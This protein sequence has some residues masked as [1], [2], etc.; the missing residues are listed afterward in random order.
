MQPNDIDALLGSIS[1]QSFKDQVKEVAPSLELS[2]NNA[3]AMQSLVTLVEEY[4][5][6]L[7]NSGT[8]KWFVEGSAFS[9][10][11]CPKHNAFFMASKSYTETLFIAGNRCGKTLA[12]AFAMAC[13]LTGEYP[14]WWNGK[15]F[16]RPIKA[17]AAGSDAKSTRDTVQKELLG[18]IGNW[19]TG[20]IPKEKMGRFWALSGVPQGVD[21]IEIKHSSGGISTLSFK[22]YQ[23][24]LSAFYGTAMDVIWLDEICPA[25]IYNECLIRTMTTGGIIFVTFTPLEGLTPLVVNF[26]S[27]ADLLAGSKPLLG[28]SN[29]QPEDDGT[30][31]RLANRTVAKA[32]V[33]AGW[34]DAP[35]LTEEAKARML[36]DTPPHLRAARS[37][38][39]PSMGSGNIYPIPLS[40]I[41]IKPFEIPPYYER[42]CG[43]DVGWNNTAAVWLAKNPD[44]G[45]VYMYDEY[46]RG[47]EEPPV[48]ASA[49]KARGTWI[50][51][52]IDPASRGR[53]QVDGRKLMDMYR[54]EDLLLYPA[55]NE[56]ESG[57]L[58][59]WSHLSTGKL[60]I[61]ETLPRIQREYTLYRRDLN[62]KVI[63]EN[64]HL[65]DALRYALNMIIRAI[66]KQQA[67]SVGKGLKGFTTSMKYDI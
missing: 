19:G 42:I 41:L 8:G 64:D 65:L 61:F 22:N 2:D 13:H 50:P 51:V 34:D 59:V 43:F 24:S 29:E 66:S 52:L 45:V 21:T 37:K 11:N 10:E 3:R 33:T 67:T 26:F 62:G 63:K 36:D 32:I 14:S 4:Q 46:I 9:I 56:V 49:I 54:A 55:N 25:D 60:K 38:G 48:H 28:V 16:D 30:D 39:E 57:I 17:W 5:S 12:G 6:S 35:W 1:T 40:E 23:Q 15:T 31:S 7:E 58:N 47:G 44:T 53:S 27:K 18:S 20:L